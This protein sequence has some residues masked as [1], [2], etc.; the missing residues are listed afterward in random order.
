MVDAAR[1]GSVGRRRGE[2]GQ[3]MNGFSKC[4]SGSEDKLVCNF[5]L[6]SG[7]IRYAAQKFMND[8][9]RPEI[10]KKIV[11]ICNYKFTCFD[12]YKTYKTITL[13][14]EI[15]LLITLLI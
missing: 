2:M 15:T 5:K 1:W 10:K 7:V 9:D 14:H 8:A 6:A 11:N 3:N 13:E 12:M 4:L